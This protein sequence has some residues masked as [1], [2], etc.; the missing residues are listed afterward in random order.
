MAG[1]RVDVEAFAEEYI[2]LADDTGS[3]RLVTEA[4]GKPPRRNVEVV[5]VLPGDGAPDG[6]LPSFSFD[7]A[8][9]FGLNSFIFELFDFGSLS[10]GGPRLILLC[11]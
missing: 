9:F 7:S 3:T 5:G 6:A 4:F 2:E 10:G 1:T 8:M 11:A